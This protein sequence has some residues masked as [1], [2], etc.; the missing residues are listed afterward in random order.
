MDGSGLSAAAGLGLG[1]SPRKTP[2]P[3]GSWAK[4][5]TE[6]KSHNGADK[7]CTLL[8][9]MKNK[10]QRKQNLREKQRAKPH[11]SSP[12]PRFLRF[13]GFTRLQR[14]RRRQREPRALMNAVSTAAPPTNHQH[15]HLQERPSPQHKAS[16]VAPPPVPAPKPPDL[17]FLGGFGYLSQSPMDLSTFH[18]QSRAS[19]PTPAGPM[20]S[21]LPVRLRNTWAWKT[22][23]SQW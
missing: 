20:C 3:S 21:T 13:S 5:D 16:A 11:V 14:L 17:G 18:S 19:D 8:L 23:M 4:H 1:P 6:A 12:G 7:H 15:K 2:S 9:L 22:S 10:S